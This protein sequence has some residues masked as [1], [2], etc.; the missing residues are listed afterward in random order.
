MVSDG[1]VDEG[2]EHD[3]APGESPDPIGERSDFDTPGSN[4]PPFE[5]VDTTTPQ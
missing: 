4:A 3:P 5:I 2:K 1:V